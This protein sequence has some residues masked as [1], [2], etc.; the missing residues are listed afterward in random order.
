[1]LRFTKDRKVYWFDTLAGTIQPM[2]GSKYTKWGYLPE[3][4]AD[5][6]PNMLRRPLYYQTQRD[7]K[8]ALKRGLR[9]ACIS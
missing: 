9:A 1:M 2:E 6:V 3:L 5:S 4:G 7:I 8:S